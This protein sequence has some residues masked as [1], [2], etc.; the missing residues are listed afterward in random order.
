VQAFADAPIYARTN[1][2]LKRWLVDIATPV[3]AGPAARRNR[4]PGSRSAVSP[5]Q[6]DLDTAQANETLG[7][8][9]FGTLER[10]AET[11]RCRSRKPMR[12]AAISKPAGLTHRHA[13]T[14]SPARHP[15]LP[16]IVATV[17]PA[18]SPHAHRCRS[19]DRNTSGGVELFHISD[20]RKLRVYVQVPQPYAPAMQVASLPICVSPSARHK[21]IRRRSCAPPMPLEREFAPLLVQLEVDNSQ[22]ELFRAPIQKCIQA[23]VP[24]GALPHSGQTP[25]FPQCRPDGRHASADDHH[26]VYE[27]DHRRPPISA[28]RWK[29]PAA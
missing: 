6:A 12:S 15:G 23:A 10:L 8:V 22:G 11:S 16:A 2:Y 29:S 26:V 3:K 19:I 25:Y 13:P 9:D 4:R 5:A 1:G 28:R 14:S 21:P 27:A 17:R 18:P 24:A 20:L 7:K